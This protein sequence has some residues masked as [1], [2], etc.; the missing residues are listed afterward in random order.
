MNEIR[1]ALRG[2]TTGGKRA[3]RE[4]DGHTLSDDIGNAGDTARKDVANARDDAR[5]KSRE[6]SSRSRDRSERS[7]R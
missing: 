6:T 5:E 4:A 7:G 3:G 1:K 2:I